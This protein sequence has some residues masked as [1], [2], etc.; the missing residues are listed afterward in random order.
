MFSTMLSTKL[1]G[2]LRTDSSDSDKANSQ[3]SKLLNRES[4]PSFPGGGG[5]RKQGAEEKATTLQDPSWGSP[6]VQSTPLFHARGMGAFFQLD[7]ENP[8]GKG[9][10]LMRMER[11]EQGSSLAA[12]WYG[13]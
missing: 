7:S 8:E 11:R 2:P 5:D 4:F 13:R 9:R 3:G 6:T 12:Y 10:G 1:I